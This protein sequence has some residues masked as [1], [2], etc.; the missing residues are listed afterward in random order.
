LDTRKAFPLYL[1]LLTVLLFFSGLG[2]RDFWAPVEPRYAEI[3]RVMFHNGEWIVPTV[4]GDLYTD[5]PMLYFWLVLLASKVA[6]TVNEWTVRLPAALGGI[7]TV[8]ATYFMGR[9]FFS[10]RI[11][12]FGA[13]I[14]AT[15]MRM[16]W[17]ARWAHIDALF[18]FFFALSI[19]FVGRSLLRKG[20]PNEILAAYVFMALAVLAKGFIGVVLPALLFIAFVLA[21]RDWSMIGAAKLHLGI[22]IFFCI[23][24]PWFFLV[25]QA[26]DG[27]WLADFVYIHHFQ[28]YTAG[29][30]HRQPYY[31]Y[32]MTLPVDF[33]PW[34]IFALAGFFTQ[35]GWRRVWAEPIPQFFLLWFAV[36]FFFFSLSDTK[37]DL[38]LMPLLPPLAL[39]VGYY[40]DALAG[41]GLPQ[42]RIYRWTGAGYFAL[43]AATGL[44]T[45]AVAR[46]FRPDAF[47]AILPASL[48]LAV[49]GVCTAWFIW[50]SRPL[51][52]LASASTMMAA[53]L[54]AVSLSVFPYLERF[55]SPRLFSEEVKKLVSPAT[56]LFIYA[57]TMHDF[58]Y[59]LEREV[60]PILRSPPEVD[61]L[62]AR[63]RHGY[64][65]VKER[66]LKRVPALALERVV[67]SSDDSDRTTWHLLELKSRL[68][69]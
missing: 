54:L 64:M 67:L 32:F 52:A 58:N 33:L 65:L 48:V 39:F 8:L 36:V 22:P 21:R 44:A 13:V 30:G 60:I 31:Y 12:F 27:K 68:G 57:D 56:P 23:A 55:K 42:D 17:E 66:D 63:G 49:G 25:N 16:I 45:P 61:A 2:E 40:F 26:T 19:Y 69:N 28:R 18:C 46:V 43:V 41:G 38:Y 10:A 24:L 11:G 15:C 50:R 7:G 4:N 14:L 20:N 5:K 1:F 62:L 29:L 59:Y 6:G 34:T 53:S 9:D 47:S 51:A 3:A 37:R 35:R